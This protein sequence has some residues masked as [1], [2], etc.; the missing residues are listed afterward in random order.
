[1]HRRGAN[2]VI[3]NVFRQAFSVVMGELQQIVFK[4]GD[5]KLDETAQRELQN[6]MFQD[7]FR[8]RLWKQP[9]QQDRVRSEMH[10][11]IQDDLRRVAF[12]HDQMARDK[13]PD[14]AQ[15]LQYF[16]IGLQ[17]ED[18]WFSRT[19]A[20]ELYFGGTLNASDLLDFM[21]WRR[22]ADQLGIV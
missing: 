4:P 19:R 10:R 6:V 13:K 9:Q 2:E 21:V 16:A 11:S 12:L 5:H 8:Q 15:L 20:D 17:F 14:I 22:Q 1:Y 3:M 7:M 18:W